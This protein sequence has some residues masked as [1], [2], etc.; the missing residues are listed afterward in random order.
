MAADF[1]LFKIDTTTIPYPTD[2]SVLSWAASAFYFGMLPGLCPMELA[3]Q[4]FNIGRI[5]G[6]MVF[7]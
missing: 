4:S 7:F 1:S 2:T 6:I 5:L 3:L